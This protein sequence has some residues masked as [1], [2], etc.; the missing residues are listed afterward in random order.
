MPVCLCVGVCTCAAA[1]GDQERA[2]DALEELQDAV[3]HP[4]EMLGMELRPSAR[5]APS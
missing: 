1:C 4:T 5:D 3:S 2:P